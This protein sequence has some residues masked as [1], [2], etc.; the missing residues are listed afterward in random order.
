MKPL[1]QSLNWQSLAWPATAFEVPAFQAHR[2]YW[3]GG[4]QENTLEAFAE[5]AT[6]G[7]E[8]FECDV[9]LTKDLVPIVFHDRDTSRFLAQSYEIRSL[10]L[11][12]LK[13]ILPMVPTLEEVFITNER[14]RLMN[15]E[16]KTDKYFE[17]FLEKKVADLVKKYRLQDQIMISSF[18]PLSLWMM[19]QF[20]PQTPRALL[21]TTQSE[22]G[23][24]FLLKNM[25]LAPVAQVHMLNL[26]HEDFSSAQIS[27]FIDQGYKV[28][29]WT[30]NDE[31]RAV[32]ELGQGVE[33]IITDMLSPQLVSK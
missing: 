5:A 19:S 22:P 30:L 26:C 11:S 25:L 27:Q 15:L 20:L 28:S 10:N 13:E 29:L 9:Q 8:M 32:E 31:A 23:N 1:L 4:A 14:P 21:A 17:A 18:N 12:E 2:G 3:A 24:N 6:Y 7:Y 16:M 33:S